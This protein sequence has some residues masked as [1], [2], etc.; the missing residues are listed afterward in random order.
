MSNLHIQLGWNPLWQNNAPAKNKENQIKLKNKK[1][2]RYKVGAA[3][4]M[5]WETTILRRG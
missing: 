4:T 1:F 2:K 5:T 3:I